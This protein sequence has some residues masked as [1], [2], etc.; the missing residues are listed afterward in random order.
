[1]AVYGRA[2]KPSFSPAALGKPKEDEMHAKAGAYCIQMPLTIIVLDPPYTPQ[3][4]THS[5]TYIIL[6]CVCASGHY[7]F[8]MSLGSDS[9]REKNEISFLCINFS[10][11]LDRKCAAL[12]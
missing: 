9:E 2:G 7:C 8:K 6:L 10:P 12:L 1:V 11:T 5:H 4:Y 3:T